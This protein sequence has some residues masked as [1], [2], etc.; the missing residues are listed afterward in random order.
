[1][2]DIN[3]FRRDINIYTERERKGNRI[4]ETDREKNRRKKVIPGR[5]SKFVNSRVDEIFFSFFH[6]FKIL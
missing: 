4:R 5:F 6:G 1:M 3:F 2:S